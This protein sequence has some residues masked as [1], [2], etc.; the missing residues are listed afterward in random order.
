MTGVHINI[1]KRISNYRIVSRR[2]RQ[3]EDALNDHEQTATVRVPSPVTLVPLNDLHTVLTDQQA[4]ED[5]HLIEGNV[6]H[7]PG[8]LLADT[9]VIT[10]V[11]SEQTSVVEEDDEDTQKT[12]ALKVSRQESTRQEALSTAAPDDLH[13]Q[14]GVQSSKLLGVV[15][16][17]TRI[18]MVIIIG[19]F[20][21]VFPRVVLPKST[22]R[23]TPQL[24]AGVAATVTVA[25]VTP[26]SSPIPGLTITPDHFNA[27][28]GCTFAQGR[29]KCIL[30]LALSKNHHNKLQW[31]VSR[32]GLTATFSPSKGRLRPGHQQQIVI[33]VY[34]NCPHSGSL[35]FSL[36]G[37]TITIPWSC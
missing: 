2:P 15:V 30:T 31:S 16:L 14:S 25:V 23:A 18:L 33:Y 19:L 22:I 34:N 26:T 10:G 8:D 32:S 6:S 4:T 28:I 27:T 12:G 9:Q 20:F 35:I 13:H 5:T 11:A 1:R 36:G 7:L 21:L 29:Y 17:V 3:S 24:P 37:K